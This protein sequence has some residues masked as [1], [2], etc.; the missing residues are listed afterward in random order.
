[1]QKTFLAVMLS[2]LPAAVAMGQGTTIAKGTV[3]YGR[4]AAASFHM[5]GGPHVALLRNRK[6]L[7]MGFRRERVFAA[8]R[9]FLFATTMEVPVSVLLP[10]ESRPA[11]AECFWRKSTGKLE[12]YA[13]LQPGMPVGAFGLTPF[14]VK[15]YVGPL[16]RVRLFGALAS[17]AIAFDRRTP[18]AKAS[19]LNFA[20]EFLLGADIG[21]G[22]GHALEV[23]WKFQHWSNA[24]LS[25]LNP[26][27]DANLITLGLKRRR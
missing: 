1:M 27:L 22:A 10:L 23:A 2:L 14:G 17:G 7:M 18:V 6:V 24:N 12:C 26:G 16:S 3:Y 9:R 21:V 5:D 20:A 19:A 15:A 11:P 4:Y 8:G 25:H 13:V